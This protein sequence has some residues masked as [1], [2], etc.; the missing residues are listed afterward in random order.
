M[1]TQ[2]WQYWVLSIFQYTVLYIYTQVNFSDVCVRHDIKNE[3]IKKQRSSLSPQHLHVLVCLTFDQWLCAGGISFAWPP[4]ERA[5][6]PQSASMSGL[7]LC[8]TT[9]T[10]NT[11]ETVKISHIFSC[12]S[13]RNQTYIFCLWDTSNTKLGYLL[14]RLLILFYWLKCGTEFMFICSNKWQ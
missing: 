14:A 12:D 5:R 7:I 1:E 2:A 13:K 9:V 10:Q 11:H 3:H 6:S 4:L 8:F